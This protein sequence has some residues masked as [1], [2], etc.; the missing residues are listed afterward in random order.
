MVTQ[1]QGVFGTMVVETKVDL[2]FF[3]LGFGSSR[4]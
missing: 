1:Y 3:G 2:A 4:S